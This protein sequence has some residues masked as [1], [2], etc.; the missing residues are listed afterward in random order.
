MWAEAKHAYRPDAAHSTDLGFEVGDR[1]KILNQ[2]DPGWWEGELKGRS[3]MFPSNYVTVVGAG[4]ARPPPVN[5][6]PTPTMPTVTSYAS[7]DAPARAEGEGKEGSSNRKKDSTTRFGV[8]ATNLAIYCG[9][10]YAIAGIVVLIWGTMKFS[11]P[12]ASKAWT[13]TD[14]IIGALCAG[15]GICIVIWEY[16]KGYARNG[17][18][19]PY[20]AFVYLILAGPGV[21]TFPTALASALFVFPIGANIAS[22]R[23]KE[24][25]TP[26]TVDNSREENLDTRSK[27]RMLFEFFVGKNPEGQ[28]GRGFV[29]TLYLLGNMVI[30]TL[31]YLGAQKSIILGPPDQNFSPWVPVAK[32]SGAVMDFNFTVLVLPVSRSLIRFIYN[33]STANQSCVSRTSRLFLKLFPLDQALEFHM[34]CAW[35]GFFAALFHV[36][37]H[38]LN[39]ALKADLVWEVFGIG[40]WITGIGLVVVMLLLFSSTHRNIKRGHFEIFWACHMMF[41]IFFVLNIFHGERGFG[42][43][44]WKWLILPGAIF[45]VERIYREKLSR[46]PVSLVSVTHMSNNVMSLAV[47]KTGAM[48]TYKEG[49]YA[50]LMCPAVSKFQWHPFT[51]SSAPQEQYATFHIRVQEPG[52]WTHKLQQYTKLMGVKGVAHCE[53]THISH[54]GITEP[55][56]ILGPDGQRLLR[57]YGPHSA[58]TQHLTEYNE[59]MICTSGIGVT[60]LA[61]AMKSIIHFRWKYFIGK[62][63]PDHAHFFWIASHN[64]IHSFRWFIRTVK[65]VEDEIYDMQAKSPQTVAGKSFEFHVF[66]TSFK[67]TKTNTDEALRIDDD[68]SFWGVK[69]KDAMNVEHEKAPFTEEQLYKAMINPAKNGDIT[70]LGH[71]TVHN[72]RPQWNQHFENV[73]ANKNGESSIGVTFCGNPGIGKTLTFLCNKYSRESPKKFHLHQE[74]F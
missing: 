66:I 40:I 11:P 37:A 74:V 36:G 56:K 32:F 50:Y 33:V 3:G 69:S 16:K 24:V 60:P 48:A 4:G 31:S 72:G 55:G 23:L 44:Y 21:M 61:A 2:D 10:F 41:P 58:P 51:I 13:S 64:E 46:Q 38:L 54:E 42:P 73:I 17:G 15:I 1:I 70:K 62:A 49:Q 71:V 39:Y 26:S 35:V 20:R 52:S 30:G 9:L 59:V 63:F 65:E 27:P 7:N 28:L 47:T 18:K 14:G 67:G 68:V 45:L 22:A 53:F 5:N 6:K 25:F 57:I 12:P 43:N 29:L 8:W 19:M 34:L